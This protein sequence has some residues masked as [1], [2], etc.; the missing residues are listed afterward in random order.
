MKSSFMKK[1]GLCAIAVVAMAGCATGGGGGGPSDDELIH[2]LIN[3]ILAALQA[4]DV[5]AMT[6]NY[7]DDFQSDQG[8]KAAMV[9]F[10]E[11]A[12]EQGFL[13]DVTVDM[14]ELEVAV[15]ESSAK[16]TGIELEGG[17]LGVLT[18]EFEL[19]KREGK[20]WVTNQI[21]Y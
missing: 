11:G 5:T 17:A 12:K 3:D 20:W 2:S 1:W 18:L 9:T 10:L 6:A 13:E 21:T 15:D 19:E 4:Q 16:V 8:D 7:A 14:E